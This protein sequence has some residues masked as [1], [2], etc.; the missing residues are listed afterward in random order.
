MITIKLNEIILTL[1]VIY[2]ERGVVTRLHEISHV[3][4]TKLCPQNISVLLK[5]SHCIFTPSKPFQHQNVTCNILFLGKK[6]KTLA[7]SI[8]LVEN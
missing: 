5:V 3:S 8:I 1:Q 4:I 7:I 6:I 2:Q